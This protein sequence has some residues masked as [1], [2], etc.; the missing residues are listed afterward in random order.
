MQK[1]AN[2][3]NIDFPKFISQFLDFFKKYGNSYIEI[4]KG[5]GFPESYPFDIFPV[6]NMEKHVMYGEMKTKWEKWLDEK[7]SDI[8]KEH[9]I[10]I[11]EGAN[12]GDWDSMGKRFYGLL[13]SAVSE[14]FN[15]KGEFINEF[16]IEISES[17]KDMV[18]DKMTVKLRL[19]N[20]NRD[21][22]F[23]VICLSYEQ[24]ESLA[25]D[26]SPFIP[27]LIRNQ[28]ISDKYNNFAEKLDKF[29]RDSKEIIYT[30]QYDDIKTLDNIIRE[31][32]RINTQYNELSDLGKKPQDILEQLVLSYQNGH[33]SIQKDEIPTGENEIIRLPVYF[34]SDDRFS[35]S[36]VEFLKE[37]THIARKEKESAESNRMNRALF[38]LQIIMTILI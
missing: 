5:E 1:Q 23:G 30:G 7:F 36:Q 6:E 35:N 19:N 11:L 21:Y 26:L 25:S 37:L 12:W 20:K 33:I 32:N 3:S 9:S 29:I 24:I 16:I 17:I 15:K 28:N 8:N 27:E 18:M 10:F 4:K 14:M 34:S 31:S 38:R 22:E 13:Q 2:N